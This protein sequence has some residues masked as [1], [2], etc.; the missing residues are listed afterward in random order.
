MAKLAEDLSSAEVERS[1]L[2][3][4]LVSAK[5]HGMQLL[6]TIEKARDDRGAAKEELQKNQSKQMHE[7][8]A[9]EGERNR[10]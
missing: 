3:G 2:A 6:V 4:K 5:S 7:R 8:L 10:L 9:W 1:K